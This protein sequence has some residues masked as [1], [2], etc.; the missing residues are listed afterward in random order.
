MLRHRWSA[1]L[2][3]HGV[4]LGLLF[5]CAACTALPPSS[6]SV[7]AADPDAQVPATR[8]RS[9]IAATTL[10]QPAEPQPWPGLNRNVAP[11]PPPDVRSEP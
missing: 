5:C 1:A 3:P 9:A 7:A 2:I 4:A 10:W 6:S 11:S 8:Y